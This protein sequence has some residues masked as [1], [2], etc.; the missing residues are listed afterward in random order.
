MSDSSQ[1]TLTW[2]QS[3]ADFEL[4]QGNHWNFQ[5]TQAVAAGQASPESNI[6][7][8]SKALAPFTAISWKDRYALN[9][10]ATL[11]LPGVELSIYGNWQPCSKGQVFDLN[12]NGFWA[13]SRAPG[14]PGWLSVGNI[15]YKYPGIPGIHI[16]VGVL[17]ATSGEYSPIFI[18]SARL[19][20]GSSAEFQPQGKLTWWLESG[21]HTSQ[22]YLGSKSKTASWDVSNP[23]H[24][25]G[26]FE[27][28]TSFIFAEG[29]WTI[30][31]E[32]PPQQLVMPPPAAFVEE[33]WP[34]QILLDPF[35]W[36]VRFGV[37]VATDSRSDLV[38]YL[39]ARLSEY[40]EGLEIAFGGDD[41]SSLTITY[42][43]VRGA[44]VGSFAAIGI[45]AG[46]TTDGSKDHINASLKDALMSGK[47]PQDETWDIM[48]GSASIDDAP[49]VEESTVEEA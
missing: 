4:I 45:I 40:F 47:L 19:P 24:S 15:N 35:G 39:H 36:M 38:D 20:R 31:E 18:D 26:K 32:A 27:W 8:K 6:I 33:S 7:W 48:P 30:S 5:I 43:A 10:T 17:D 2:W 23:A 13:P 34:L 22:V 37:V 3:R 46:S 29:E 25:T 21:T 42:K 12:E 14:K 16:V 1:R 44:Q 49:T 11:P 41:G 9:W 28:W